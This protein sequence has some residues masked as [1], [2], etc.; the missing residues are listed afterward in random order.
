MPIWPSLNRT[1]YFFLTI[2]FAVTVITFAITTISNYLQEPFIPTDLPDQE[3]P[4]CVGPSDKPSWW[5]PVSLTNSRSIHLD[6]KNPQVHVSV[7]VNE[8]SGHTLSYG[9]PIF[10]WLTTWS[11][12]GARFADLP[13]QSSSGSAGCFLSPDWGGCGGIRFIFI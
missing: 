3:A 12:Y 9:Y 6:L 7:Y 11:V 10:P 2:H 8:P 1:R 4:K 5:V 13:V